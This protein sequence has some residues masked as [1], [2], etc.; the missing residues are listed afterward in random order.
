M[1]SPEVSAP[2]LLY[3]GC[4]L[5]E[6]RCAPVYAYAKGSVVQLLTEKVTCFGIFSLQDASGLPWPPQPPRCP[7]VPPFSRWGRR[8]LRHGSSK[9]IKYFGVLR[10]GKP[11]PQNDHTI[12]AKWSPNGCKMDPYWLQMHHGSIGVRSLCAKRPTL[13]KHQY[14]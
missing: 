14:L 5:R 6:G 12:A 2:Q 4:G 7:P 9:Q 13:T 10:P 1:V 11:T 3:A 8:W